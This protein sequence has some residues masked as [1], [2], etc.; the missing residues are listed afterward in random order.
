MLAAAVLEIAAS[1]VVELEA[2]LVEVAEVV[3]LETGLG[4]TMEIVFLTDGVL[5]GRPQF[6]QPPLAVTVTVCVS[7]T[8]L[9]TT[10]LL[11]N[12][13]VAMITEDKRHIAR[14]MV[15]IVVKESLLGFEVTSQVHASCTFRY[16]GRLVDRSNATRP[17]DNIKLEVL[18]GMKSVLDKN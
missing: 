11:S 4:L 14:L 5:E 15:F 17:Q 3:E 16:N 10:Y 18:E 6:H 12:R 9:V 8:T 2:E 13:G 7:S 1:E